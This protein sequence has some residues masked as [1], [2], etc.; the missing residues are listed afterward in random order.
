MT[1]TLTDKI[2]LA[3][4][5]GVIC[6]YNK[7]LLMFAHTK[8]GAP[9]FTKEDCTLFNT[10][11][12]FPQEFRSE[13]DQLANEPGFFAGLDVIDGAI[14]ALREMEAMGLN[15]FICTSPKKFYRNSY[16]AGEKHRWIMK[17]LGKHW[18]E[19]IILTRDKTLVY[20]DMLIDDKPEITG[21][22]KPTW[23]HVY[24]DQP[25]NRG[26][27]KPRITKWSSWKEELLPL[28]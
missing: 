12:V 7:T 19:K 9:L 6:D 16:C 1:Y 15:V 14:E 20:G 4:M 3:D 24:F 22:M 21:A 25:Y 26:I 2:V 28:L 8:L 18:T 10:E 23:K 13:V 27:N 11:E 17:H 5:D